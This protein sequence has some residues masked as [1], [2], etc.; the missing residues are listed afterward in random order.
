MLD[1]EPAVDGDRVVDRRD[2]R[3]A[4]ALDQQQAVAEALVVVDEVEV[5][6]SAAQVVPRAEAERERLGELAGRERRDL[7]EVGPALELPEARHPHREVVVVDVQ[8][9]QLDQRHPLVEDRVGLAAQHLDVVAEVDQRLGEV[10]G[11]DAL[12]AD[13]GLAPVGEECD[14]EGAAWRTWGE[15]LPRRLTRRSN[16]PSDQGQTSE[17]GSPSATAPA[18]ATLA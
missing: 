13:V 16:E 8:A 3:E 6:G 14:A 12:A 1:L 10:A 2:D 5:G 15:S 4:H 17:T 18:S 7:D 11:V 9:R